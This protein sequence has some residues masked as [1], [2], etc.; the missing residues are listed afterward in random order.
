MRHI[1]SV[2]AG[3]S[4]LHAFALTVH[5][6]PRG[7]AAAAQAQIRSA[8][9]RLEWAAC[10][11]RDA[12]LRYDD[13]ARRHAGAIN[14]WQRAIA[15]RDAAAR[16]ISSA[17]VELPN[18]EQALEAAGHLLQRSIVRLV[19]KTGRSGPSNLCNT[20]REFL[21]EELMHSIHDACTHVAPISHELLTRN[22]N[23]FL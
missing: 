10:E 3:F 1:L 7:E 19:K 9:A 13:L 4:L 6:D 11:V 20:W 8:E 18:L 5:A 17:Q 15:D 21:V 22:S 14:D 16:T 12:R 23:L 2:V